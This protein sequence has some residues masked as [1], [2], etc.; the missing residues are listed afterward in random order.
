[1]STK[2]DTAKQEKSTKPKKP[3]G[4]SWK[5]GVSGNPN[6]RPKTGE[7]VA[8]YVREILEEN[9]GER[10]TKIIMRAYNAAIDKNVEEAD[11]ERW[12]RF[13]FDRAYGKP[14]ESFEGSIDLSYKITPR[15]KDVE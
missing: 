2:K 1:M 8:E 6:G 12:A 15:K 3:R 4:G 10:R 14:K 7:S 5:K 9:D 13:L 11:A